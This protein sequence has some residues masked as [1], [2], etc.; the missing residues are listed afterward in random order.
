MARKI[1][2]TITEDELIKIVKATKKKK[3]R[4]AFMLGFYQAMRVSEVVNLQ[5]NNI[6]YDR[7]YIE[8]KNAKG[9][10]DR[11]IPIIKPLLLKDNVMKLG[12]KHLPIGIGKRGLQLAFKKAGIKTLGKDLHFHTLRHSGATWL[13]NKKKWDIRQVQ[14]FLGHSKISTTEIYAHVGAEALVELEWGE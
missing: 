6:Q 2:E 7:N 11:D 13:M 9:S 8:I 1:P 12:L 14:V 5:K 10:K 4:L 3:H